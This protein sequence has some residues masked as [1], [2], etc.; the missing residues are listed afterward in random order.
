MKEQE[1][2]ETFGIKGTSA[3]GESKDKYKDSKGRW[4]TVSLF[5][6]LRNNTTS[7]EDPLFTLAETH[8]IIDGVTYQSLKQLYLETEDTTEYL[9]VTEVLGT[10][11]R[12]WKKLIENKII[13]E[14]VLEWR[15]ELEIKLRAKGIRQTVELA[16]S[17][18][19]SASKLLID[20]GWLDKKKLD[21]TKDK[22]KDETS[23]HLE[24]F[25]QRIK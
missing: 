16:E 19:Y 20:R 10:S 12:H 14:H 24:R 13:T 18:N 17:G 5:W 9:F 23:D 1:V 11:W 15:E 22:V 3:S 7:T 25:M 2:I 8:R 4:R 21:S 6:E